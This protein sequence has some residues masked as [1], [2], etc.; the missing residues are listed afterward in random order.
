MPKA[1]LTYK[2]QKFV[3]LYEG[4]ATEAARLA[5]YS[6]NDNTLATIGDENMRKHAIIEALAKRD[7]KSEHSDM[8]KSRTARRKWLVDLIEG[9]I[10]IDSELSDRLS[11]IDKLLRASGDYITRH[12]LADEHGDAIK[13]PPI[14]F[15]LGVVPK[16][17]E[18]GSIETD[19]N[20][21][22]KHKNNST[23]VEGVD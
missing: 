4:N 18:K 10:E 9:R 1:K 12:Q 19:N 5:G 14:T 13:F 3:D 20:S 22:D 15:V 21:Q 2:Q 17:L 23:A 8:L 16:E 11:A 6:G 7:A